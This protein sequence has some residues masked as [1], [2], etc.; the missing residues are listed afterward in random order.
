MRRRGV[1]RQ[2]TGAYFPKRSGDWHGYVCICPGIYNSKCSHEI[3]DTRGGKL[4]ARQFWLFTIFRG[5]K[6]LIS[7]LFISAK[8]ERHTNHQIRKSLKEALYSRVYSSSKL[9]LHTHRSRCFMPNS[10]DVE[11]HFLFRTQL[12][13]FTER[14]FLKVYVEEQA[15]WKISETPELCSSGLTAFL[16]WDTL[17]C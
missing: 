9:S 16:K 13:W 7:K 4:I 1:N 6:H 11:F 8:S 10:N 5:F 17:I 12:S 3:P 2:E 15:H 14:L